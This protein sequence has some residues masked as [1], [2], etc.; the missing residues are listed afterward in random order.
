MNFSFNIKAACSLA[1]VALSFVSPASADDSVSFRAQIAPILLD[2]CVA[3]H[4]AKKAE[5]GYRL[6]AFAELSKAGDSDIDPLKKSGETHG[7]LLRRVTSTD[8]SERMP[9]ESDPLTK[10]QI[11][12][13]TN[14]LD[15]GA[16]FD[17]DDPAQ[18]LPFVV[19]PTTYPSPPTTYPVP[20]QVT[21][22]TFTPDGANIVTGGYHEL[23]V[24]D[25][26]GK[27]VRRIEN[28]G[29]QVF[30]LAF[31]PDGQ[32]LA[33]AC[34]QP[35]QSGEVR[36]VDFGSGKVVAVLGRS[37]DVIWDV[38]IRPGGNDIAI[39]AADK[40]I[41]LVDL[42][43]LD[44]KLNLQSHADWVTSIGWTADGKQL[45]STSR[46][47]S[48]KVFDVDNGQL[49]VSY[50]DHNAA[51]RGVSISTDGK[52]AYSVGGDNQ[53]RR[54]N[55]ADGKTVKAVGLGSEGFQSVAG[56]GW[57][58]VPCSDHRLLK[59]DIAKDQV[60]QEFKGHTDWVLSVAINPD[61]SHIAT[62]SYDGEI[63]LWDAAAGTTIKQWFA[64]P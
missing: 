8:E 23:L 49:L 3:C 5:G 11:A 31:H 41:R 46:D 44:E 32:R 59:I 2:N 37:T 50:K 34:G 28:I 43:T 39:A 40:S 45:I 10:D 26:E 17:G 58:L 27:L 47:K 54:W 48:A 35:G 1:L 62:G 30:D 4:N 61:Q 14:W 13:L 16:A 57:I 63:R 51:V 55:L 12:L 42:S 36:I 56:K 15:A 52:Q 38:A 29:Q 25:L 9:P 18:L 60:V 53:Y 20:V 22:V 21:A 24:W 64:K 33:V 19:P 7:E 6:D